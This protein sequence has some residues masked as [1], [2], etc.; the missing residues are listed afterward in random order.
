[1]AVGRATAEISVFATDG[2]IPNNFL[3]YIEVSQMVD[4]KAT[5]PFIQHGEHE[6]RTFGQR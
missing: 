3:I 2:R 1:M 5:Q 4:D 6:R